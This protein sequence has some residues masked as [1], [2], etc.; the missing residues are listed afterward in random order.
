[1][2]SKNNKISM[3]MVEGSIND[4]TVFFVLHPFSCMPHLLMYLLSD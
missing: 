1:M 2:K 3:V 4:Y